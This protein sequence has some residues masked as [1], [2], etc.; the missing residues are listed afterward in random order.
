MKAWYVTDRHDP[1]ELNDIVHGDTRGKA[2]LAS[3]MFRDGDSEFTDLRAKREPL[4]DDKDITLR[5]IA[6]AGY[7]VMCERCA[8]W[9]SDPERAKFRDELPYHARCLEVKDD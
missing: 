1:W 7:A 5:N 2:K 3:W 6:G 8:V 4:L 9:I